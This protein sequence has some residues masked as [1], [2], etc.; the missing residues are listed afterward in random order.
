MLQFFLACKSRS[1]FHET[2]QKGLIW[3]Q[4]GLSVLWPLESDCFTGVNIF[5]TGFLREYCNWETF[6]ANCTHGHVIM[7][8]EAQYG[9]M[10]FGRCIRKTYD[11]SGKPVDVG[12]KQ[13]IIK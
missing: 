11:D 8:T 6:K 13:D 7:M 3:P 9:R 1:Q 5:S 12:C 10:K 2:T 4:V